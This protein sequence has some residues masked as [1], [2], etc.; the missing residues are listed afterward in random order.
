MTE[1][2]HTHEAIDRSILSDA[3]Y[4]ACAAVFIEVEHASGLCTLRTSG[5][6][7]TGADL[8]YLGAKL[9]QIR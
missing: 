3:R 7:A 6:F 1:T 8:D 4:G 2:T 5:R 9:D